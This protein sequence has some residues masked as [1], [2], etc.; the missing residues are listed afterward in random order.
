[1]MNNLSSVP[2]IQSAKAR[3][4]L[5]GF[6]GAIFV[7][8]YK[9]IKIVCKLHCK[10]FLAPTVWAKYFLLTKDEA[11]LLDNCYAGKGW[12]SRFC[13]LAGASS[14]QFHKWDLN[15]GASDVV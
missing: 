8:Y 7:C 10:I 15:I 4:I 5:E 1:M 3:L 12:P 14:R 9:Q 11:S 6:F 13:A 2:T